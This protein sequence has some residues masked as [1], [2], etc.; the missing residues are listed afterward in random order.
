MNKLLIT[1]IYLLI[2]TT[3]VT[4][5]QPID[6][7][8]EPLSYLRP[9]LTN[10]LTSTAS[11]SHN[12]NGNMR[13]I[14]GIHVKELNR[15]HDFNNT[16][17]VR[18]AEM[19]LGYPVFGGEI[20]MHAPNHPQ[21][22]STAALLR[23]AMAPDAYLT[24]TMYQNLLADLAGTPAYIF[25][26]E[27]A[28]KA[29]THTIQEFLHATNNQHKK[30]EQPQSQLMVYIDTHN[31]AHWAFL[32]SF[33][34]P[35]IHG[36]SMPINPHY[37]L[38]ALSFHEYIKWNDVKTAY[39]T[40]Y[41]NAYSGGFGGN[42]K[43][44][45]LI[46]DG[47]P[48]NLPAL[49]I[50]RDYATNT[51]YLQNTDII[52]QDDRTNQVAQFPCY[53]LDPTHNHVYWNGDYDAINGAYSPSNDALFIGK[54]IKNMY[55]DWYHVPVLAEQDTPMLPSILKMVVH[56][57]PDTKG[58]I[59]PDNAFWDPIK[60]EMVFG[61]G[62][63]IFYPLTSLEIAAHE[64]SHGF[65]A[66]HSNLVYQGQSGAIN[67][68][69]SDMAAKAAEY[70]MYNSNTWDIGKEVMKQ[71]G[72]VLRYLDQPSK[73]CRDYLPGEQCSIDSANQYKKS[74]DV[75]FSSGVYN[76]VFYLIATTPGWDTKKAFDVM[77]QANMH[78][79]TPNTTFLTGACDIIRAAQ[80][81]HYPPDAIIAAFSKIQ[82]DT[83]QC[84]IR[85]ANT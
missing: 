75:H 71:P 70:Y 23:T 80:D 36:Q 69:F 20:V 31:K 47:A 85:I 57:V 76:H 48:K 52:V 18:M 58:I 28:N 2:Y 77:V 74:L 1:G 39:T 63:R 46:Y 42:Q 26:A 40:A 62:A 68:A 49:A 81:Y 55:Q 59:D 19:Y 17:H 73:D 12:M 65:T 41:T 64:I 32:T 60:K 78:Y 13:F 29:L 43:I 37:I 10:T 38:D 24:G 34:V 9:L 15:K 44:G 53:T 72:Q 30:I 3:H 35:A 84:N 7:S 66:Q 25:N 67:E 83:Q 6:V 14:A 33:Y 45:K 79:W 27:Q 21:S 50:Q 11:I 4:A 5:A 51:C 8:R 16:L 82:I 61:D 56:M 22:T 54:I